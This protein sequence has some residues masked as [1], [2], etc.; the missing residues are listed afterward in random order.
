MKKKITKLLASGQKQRRYFVDINRG[1]YVLVK[2]QKRTK[3]LKNTDR[4]EK[5]G[6][7]LI[8]MDS[9]DIDK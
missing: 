6:V 4:F 1:K 3:A 8:H 5:N 9:N 7:H 2:I